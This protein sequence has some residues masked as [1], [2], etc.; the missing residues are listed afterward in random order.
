MTKEHLITPQGEVENCIF[1][2]VG[3]STKGMAFGPAD[4]LALCPKELIADMAVSQVSLW[5]LLKAKVRYWNR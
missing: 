3:F 2:G 5:K 1:Y 4:G